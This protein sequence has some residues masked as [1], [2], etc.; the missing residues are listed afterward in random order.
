MIDPLQG[1]AISS[2]YLMG[3]SFACGSLF[4]VIILLGLEFARRN[5]NKDQ[6]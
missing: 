2:I 4:T 3:A 1:C 5:Q 6:H